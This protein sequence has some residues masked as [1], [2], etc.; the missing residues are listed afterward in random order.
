MK[1]RDHSWVDTANVCAIIAAAILVCE[2]ADH[3]LSHV[4]PRVLGL[5]TQI[6]GTIVLMLWLII[7]GYEKFLKPRHDDVGLVTLGLTDQKF[8]RTSS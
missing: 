3:V 6:L 2:L 8:D 4:I 5:S 7:K 1:D